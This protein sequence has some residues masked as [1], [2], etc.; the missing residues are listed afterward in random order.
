[1]SGQLRFPRSCQNCD[2]E[3][4]C[5]AYPI[6]GGCD[7]FVSSN[8]AKSRIVVM[9]T[10]QSESIDRRA[11]LLHTRAA[12]APDE[13]ARTCGECASFEA[14]RSMAVGRDE[15]ADRPR[16][17]P[18]CT[19]FRATVLQP[20]LPKSPT[21]TE[22]Q[23]G[24]QAAPVA[25]LAREVVAPDFSKAGFGKPAAGEA[26]P[27]A[28]ALVT[29]GDG[30]LAM[31]TLEIAKLTGK[32]HKN[33]LAD[34]P[35]C[36]GG[37]LGVAAGLRDAASDLRR[38]RGCMTYDRTPPPASTWRLTPVHR[39]TLKALCRLGCHKLVASELQVSTRTVED[40]LLRIK[41]ANEMEHVHIIP[42]MVEWDRHSRGIQ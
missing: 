12:V 18:A 13:R 8:G 23:T 11:N 25:D 32:D 38:G 5:P 29:L 22:S 16:N 1:M 27:A 39:L 42:L 2:A 31:S 21:C 10:A 36:A 33:V 7:A 14:C 40:R 19:L 41:R 24:D 20:S 30:R 37:P 34:A 15:K 28:D 26:A 6:A 35:G 4:I 17:T 9:T 3:S